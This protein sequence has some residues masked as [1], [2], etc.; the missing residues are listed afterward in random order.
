MSMKLL[1][2]VARWNR[3]LAKPLRQRWGL[4]HLA[5]LLSAVAVILPLAAFGQEE[6]RPPV[7]PPVEVVAPAGSPEVIAPENSP[8]AITPPAVPGERIIYIPFTKLEGTFEEPG[9]SVVL[10]YDEYLKLRKQWEAAQQPAMPVGVVLTQADYVAVVEQDFAKITLTLQADVLGKSWS[11]VPVSFGEAAIGKV[12]GDNVLIRGTGPG[13]YELL[14]GNTGKQTI[15]IELGAKVH[16]SPDGRQ[17]ALAVPTV[18]VQTLD[19]T[20]PDADQTIEVSPGGTLLPVEATP[21]KSTRLISTLIAANTLSVAW[22]AKASQKPEMDLLASVN[23]RTIVSVADGLIHTDT[24][25]TYDVLR[26]KLSQFLIAVPLDQQIL[27][28]NANVQ[29]RSWKPTVMAGRQVVD[30]ELLTPSEQPVTLEVHTQRKLPDGNFDLIGL[31]EEGT[32]YGIHS[33]DAVRESGQ[34]VV[35]HAP[36]L[37]LSMGEQSGLIRIE[38]SA[39]DELLA[40]GTN[41]LAF[42]FYSQKLRLQLGVKPVEPR[43]TATNKLEVVFNEDELRCN[44]NLQYLIERTGIFELQL[45]VPENFTIDEVNCDS[46][47]EYNVDDATQILTISLAERHQGGLNV[48][49]NGHRKFDASMDNTQQA[50]PLIEP[51]NVERETGSVLVFARDAIE[52]ITNLAGLA[53]AQPLPTGPQNRGDARLAS[54]WSFTKRP[55]TIPVSTVRKPTRISAEIASVIDMQPEVTE[56][57]HTVDFFVEYAGV[58]TFQLDIPETVNDRVRIEAAAE[59][60]VAIKQKT[61]GE[62]NAGWVTW[63]IVMQREVVGHQVFSVSWHVQSVADESTPATVSALVPASAPADA[64]NV[65]APSDNNFLL[66]RPHGLLDDSGE[67]TTPLS[68]VY[69]EVVITKER[70][71]SLNTTAEGA[72][73]EAID[74]RELRLLPPEGTQGYRYFKLPETGTSTITIT[75]T[76]HEIQEVVAT[77]ISRALVEIVTGE[78]AEAT[79]RCRMQIKS[80]E[81]QRLLVNLPVGMQVLGTFVNDREI[82]L[83]KAE[84]AVGETAGAL[85]E[86]YWVNV[87][88]A[89]SSDEPF[90][91][92]FQFLWTVNPALGTSQFGQGRMGLPLLIVGGAGKGFA[93]QELQVVLWVPEA[94]TLVG[95]PREFKLRRMPRRLVDVLL[96][97]RPDHEV[98]QLDAWV[99]EGCSASTGFLQF[100]TQGRQPYVYTNLGGSSLIKV[101][102]WHR[103][104]MTLIFSGAAAL[105]GLILLAT[106][107]ENKLGILLLAAFAAALYGVRD[108]HGLYAGLEAAQFGVMVLLGLWVLHGLFGWLKAM[109]ATGTRSV[110]LASAPPGTPNP[111]TAPPVVPP[112]GSF[113]DPWKF[114][115]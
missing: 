79:Y 15:I 114:G 96:G 67:V 87:A 62:P 95:D 86:P 89:G 69:G 20:V 80:T 26:G 42:K 45:R 56:V 14:F 1:F 19:V 58:D 75:R 54:A 43:L 97:T 73:I 101:V 85:W 53:G 27:D 25:L 88:R 35:R 50:L 99:Q 106:P 113:D 59:N 102:W 52:V 2:S 28:I 111:L 91:L 68:K 8:E 48:Q 98:L 109:P 3:C 61:A 39:V 46:M 9:S 72:D 83:E 76:R 40:A 81:R 4:C 108:S 10:P 84:L 7:V 5:T 38:Q 70:S 23:N 92:T 78:D 93:V 13:T 112:P 74:I 104:S 103:L 24:W 31:T 17:F 12:E 64:A 63:T 82:K 32:T 30:I 100:P 107:W 41:A 34:V 110:P 105:I 47:K 71:L 18:G 16:Q 21:E 37:M 33:L 77:V 94:Y 22:R 57:Q 66:V 115:K 60:N 55:L 6:E 11:S 51:L 90:L 29:L 65:P 44:A 49:I 36:D